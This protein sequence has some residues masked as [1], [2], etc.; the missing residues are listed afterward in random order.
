MKKILTVLG[1]VSAFL[2]LVAA[3]YDYLLE[4]GEK[5]VKSSECNECHKL[6]YEEWSKDIHAKAYVND[7]F[8]KASRNYAAEECIGCH[9]AQD[10]A[11]GI[12][13]KIRPINKEEGINCTT[14]HLKNNMIYGPYKLTAKHKSEQDE[15]M[16]KSEF[17]IGCHTPTFQEW[18]ASGSKKSCQECHMPRVERKVVQGFLLSKVVPNRMVGQHLQSYEKLIKEAASITSEAGKGMVKISVMNKGADHLMPTGEYGDYRVV[19]NTTVKE[20]EGQVV[21]S[22]EEIFSTLKKNGIPPQKTI[23]FEYPISLETGKRYQV[24]SRLL[25]QVGTRP[26]QPMTSW[27]TVID[28]GK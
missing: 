1:L 9:A 15:S 11:E 14:C 2:F 7:P 8:K 25:Y 13:L 24:S 26:E 5:T 16:L 6:I 4:M 19:L 28:G 23:S 17:C 3:K 21:L 20:A 18:Q 10:I 22:K 27:N 12:N